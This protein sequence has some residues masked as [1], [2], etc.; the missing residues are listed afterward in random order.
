MK[1]RKACRSH[2]RFKTDSKEKWA[3]VQEVK[4]KTIL[5]LFFSS[6]SPHNQFKTFLNYAVK[7][8]L[9]RCRFQVATAQTCSS[10][11]MIIWYVFPILKSI[12]FVVCQSLSFV[13]LLIIRSHDITMYVRSDQCKN[14]A[15]KKYTTTPH[16]YFCYSM[17]N[18]RWT[19]MMKQ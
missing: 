4:R 8:L 12:P 19:F 2:W 5:N 18:N 15:K 11:P 10:Y 17:K 3:L 14:Q 9:V 16:C 6:L 13:A 1:L 7:V